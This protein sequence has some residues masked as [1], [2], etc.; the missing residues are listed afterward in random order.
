M[1]ND[2]LLKNINK[3]M[4]HDPYILEVFKSTGYSLDLLDQYIE[5][6]AAQMDVDRA[7][8]GLDLY[9]REAGIAIDHNRGYA[10][11]RSGIKAKWRSSGKADIDLLQAVADSW[12]NG[13]IKVEFRTDGLIHLTFSGEYGVPERLDGLEKAI[14]EVKPAHLDIAYH[15]MYLLVKNVHGIKINELQNLKIGAFAFITGGK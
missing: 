13:T 7:T 12:K 5:D 11:R 2:Q 3:E 14:D 9:E 1:R 15:F 10:E 6:I 4:R 8:W